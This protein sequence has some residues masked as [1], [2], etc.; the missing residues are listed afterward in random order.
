ME[1]DRAGFV[2]QTKSPSSAGHGDGM[3]QAVEIVSEP[4]KT[5]VY[6]IFNYHFP[7]PPAARPSALEG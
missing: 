1:W 7:F 5:L 4:P 3:I 2:L 6:V